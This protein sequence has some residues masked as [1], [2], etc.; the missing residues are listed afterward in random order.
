MG[1]E[2]KKVTSRLGKKNRNEGKFI[3]LARKKAFQ[4]KKNQKKYFTYAP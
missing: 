1:H 3:N 4:K 2:F